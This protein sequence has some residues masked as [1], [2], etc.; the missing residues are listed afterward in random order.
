MCILTRRLYARVRVSYNVCYSIAVM[1]TVSSV[2]NAKGAVVGSVLLPPKKN[3][4]GPIDDKVYNFSVCIMESGLLLQAMLDV[5]HHPHRERHIRLFKFALMFFRAHS[6]YSKYAYEIV[7]FLVHQLCTLSEKTAHEEYYGMFVN[8]KGTVG[9]CIPCDLAME[10]TVKKIKWNVKH[11]NSGVNDS[12]IEQRSSANSVLMDIGDNFDSQVMCVARCQSHSHI[13]ATGD[14]QEV[15][16]VLSTK[17]L[18]NKIGKR[19]HSKFANISSSTWNKIDLL[20][21]KRWLTDKVEEYSF[22]LGN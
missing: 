17:Q 18:L 13:T 15:V 9:N 3:M 8:S 11:M 5:T 4:D 10:H 16:E 14:M 2:V 19:E 7:R 1:G 6:L 12:Y 22:E 21:M 20:K